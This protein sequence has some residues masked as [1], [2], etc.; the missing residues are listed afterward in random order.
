M[1]AGR[2]AP[3]HDPTAERTADQSTQ[4]A[5]GLHKDVDG[6]RPGPGAGPGPE[7]VRDADDTAY[8]NDEDLYETPRRYDSGDNDDHP[9][10]PPDESSLNTKL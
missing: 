3:Q 10:M 2:R 5:G 1:T 4:D 6:I 7:V 8:R 9:V